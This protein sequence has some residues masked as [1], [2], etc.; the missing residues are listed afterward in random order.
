[1]L[2]VWHVALLACDAL[3]TKRARPP[4]IIG[5]LEELAIQSSVAGLEL[6]AAHAEFGLFERRRPG[7]SAVGLLAVRRIIWHDSTFGR[8]AEPPITS[9]MA[10]RARHS[11]PL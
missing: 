10:N 7:G 2:A 9:D 5:V 1:M 8:R 6:V 11:H 3:L 4:F